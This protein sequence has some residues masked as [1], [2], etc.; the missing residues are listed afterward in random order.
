MAALQDLTALY[1][2]TFNMSW[3]F[4]GMSQKRQLC[5]HAVVSCRF[6]DRYSLLTALA[7]VDYSKFEYQHFVD[8]PF[9]AV[10]IYVLLI[11]VVI[12]PIVGGKKRDFKFVT[13]VWNAFLCLLSV[14]MFLGSLQHLGA[15]LLS[16]GISETICDPNRDMFREGPWIFWGY[17]FVWSKFIE[18][19]DTILM[20]AKGRK[21]DFLHWFHHVTV[22]L[23]TWYATF[24]AYSPGWFFLTINS[25][26]HT[27]MYYYYA[28]ATLG[29]RPWWAKILTV[30]QIAQMFIGIAINGYWGYLYSNGGN[31]SCVQPY[32]IM[33][34][35][36]AMYGVYLFLFLKFFVKKY[37]SPK[38]R[39]KNA[40]PSAAKKT[41]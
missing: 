25:L 13:F 30:G 26:I 7:S 37:S 24:W 38:T 4:E 41:K 32:L 27:F 16:S 15:K 23:F 34:S 10:I 31:C 8:V 33:G 36:I 28:V 20:V 5:S 14:C 2:A 18:L 6:F 35:A 40:R 17:V 1:D 39:S 9:S 3:D 21:P 22:L 29:R 11:F 12:P 19:F